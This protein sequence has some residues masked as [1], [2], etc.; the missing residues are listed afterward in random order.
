MVVVD[1]NVRVYTAD[2]D[3]PYHEACREWIEQRRRGADA[4]YCT[5]A[6]VYEFLRVTTHP[7]VM[8]K[9]WTAPAAWE[10][11]GALFVSTG[12]GMLVQTERHVDVAAKVI[13]ELP[14]ISGN[15]M[16]DAHTA[17]LMREH[18]IRRICTRDSD[19]HGFPFVE[20]VDPLRS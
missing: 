11:V 19:F 6:I 7:R 8:R 2:V 9:P 17:I 15:L 10:F 13:A 14:R 5:W 3:S 12:L 1:T 4:W 16:H 20:V 18:G